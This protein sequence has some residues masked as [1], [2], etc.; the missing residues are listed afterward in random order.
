MLTKKPS[1]PRR[2]N[3]SSLP[4]WSSHACFAE[5]RHGPHGLPSH[6]RLNAS[7][8]SIPARGFHSRAGSVGI[9]PAARQPDAPAPRPGAPGPNVPRCRPCESSCAR[10]AASRRGAGP[11][12][13]PA[14]ARQLDG[15]PHGLEGRALA[16]PAP[17]E[18][19]TIRA[20][21]AKTALPSR[22]GSKMGADRARCV[23]HEPAL[24]V[25]CPPGQRF[26]YS[27][28]PLA[29]CPFKR[30]VLG[31]SPSPQILNDPKSLYHRP[32]GASGSD[33]RHS[34]SL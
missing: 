15:E 10:C 28:F 23:R 12:R 8:V 19:V 33:S 34:F 17:R 13:A 3:Q 25:N 20:R 18:W 21:H 31:N 7:S 32:S 9:M 4:S 16:E 6:L 27:D 11:T 22:H 1:W 2:R 5:H 24:K 30:N 26:A 29:A 14:P